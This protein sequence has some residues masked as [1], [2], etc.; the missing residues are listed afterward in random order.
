MCLEF[1]KGVSLERVRGLT[2]SWVEVWKYTSQHTLCVG[3][4]VWRHNIFL[5]DAKLA[6]NFKIWE[7]II[8]QWHM[9][10]YKSY[11]IDCTQVDGSSVINLLVERDSNQSYST[12]NFYNSADCS[13]RIIRWLLYK[14]IYNSN[15]DLDPCC[16]RWDYEYWWSSNCAKTIQA[17]FI[18]NW[19][20]SI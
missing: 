5:T 1:S 18:I 17:R 13:I 16:I 12:T 10:T 8:L 15:I 14:S 6:G 19:R 2:I 11:Y 20:L 3:T 4:G 9:C 7:L